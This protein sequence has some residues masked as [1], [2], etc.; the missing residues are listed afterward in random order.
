MSDITLNN[1]RPSQVLLPHKQ[2]LQACSLVPWGVVSAEIV[3]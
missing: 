1:A 3:L 2:L